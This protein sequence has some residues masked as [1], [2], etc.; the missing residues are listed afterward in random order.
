M[1]KEATM[2][3][4]KPIR[5][6]LA[7]AALAVLSLTLVAAA[8]IANGDDSRPSKYRTSERLVV[9]GD[10]T[11]TDNCDPNAC[12][13]QLTDGEFRGTPVGSGPYTG[14]INLKTADAFPNGEGGVCAPIQARI[15]LGAGTPDRLVLAVWGDSCQDGA[16]D[17]STT[18]FT[19]LAQFVVVRGTGSY[20]KASGSGT[21]SFLEDAADHDRMTL[22][23][24]ISQ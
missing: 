24:R 5:R 7:V 22:I 16:G 18:S 13:L 6:A 1:P 21:A 9:R 15:E 10:A 23:G 4:R 11:V 12:Q 2:P 14:D 19:G 8:A 3:Y 17:P 20:S